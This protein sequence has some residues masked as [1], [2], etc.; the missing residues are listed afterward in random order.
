MSIGSTLGTLFLVVGPITT[1]QDMR[2]G[3]PR[4]PL[5]VVASRE[6][7]GR[8]LSGAGRTEKVT[9]SQDRCITPGGPVERAGR[10]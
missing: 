3:P 6:G 7:Q 5:A 10:Q 2:R 4:Y 9:Q 8:I 1:R